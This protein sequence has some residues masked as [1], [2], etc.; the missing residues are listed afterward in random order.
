MP[1]N[2][3]AEMLNF[4]KD[5]IIDE[6]ENIHNFCLKDSSGAKLCFKFSQNPKIPYVPDDLAKREL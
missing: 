4:K 1:Y 5:K 3:W 2:V 6:T